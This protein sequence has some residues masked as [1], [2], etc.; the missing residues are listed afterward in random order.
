MQN[1]YLKNMDLSNEIGKKI[2]IPKE[3]KAVLSNEPDIKRREIS[4]HL[5]ENNNFCQTLISYD[6]SGNDITETVKKYDDYLKIEK[7][8]N[9]AYNYGYKLTKIQ[10]KKDN[11]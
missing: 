4:R 3:I 6:S 8:C 9:I 5:D 11:E 2:P 10:N 7:L 1:K